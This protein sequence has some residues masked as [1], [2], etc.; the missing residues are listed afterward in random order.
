MDVIL[1]IMAIIAVMVIGWWII[2]AL[3]KCLGIK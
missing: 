2:D 3:L 1:G